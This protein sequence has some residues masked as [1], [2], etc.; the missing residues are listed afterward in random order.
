MDGRGVPLI[1]RLTA[2]RV[3]L[4][5]NA[6]LAVCLGAES[7]DLG[8]RSIPLDDPK[9]RETLGGLNGA[10]LPGLSGLGPL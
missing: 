6:Q 8:E 9:E 4:Q 2:G 3:G 5:G 7:Q 10:Y 1:P